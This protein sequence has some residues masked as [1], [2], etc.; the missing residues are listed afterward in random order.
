MI[1]W[2]DDRRNPAENGY[3][4][5]AWAKTYDEAIASLET[6]EVELCSL[7]HDLTMS[8]TLGLT[9]EEKTG[10]NVIC[11]MEE[12]NIWPEQGVL[13]HSQNAA[14]RHRMLQVVQK[15]YGKLFQSPFYL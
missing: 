4:G 9:N 7:D 12:H 15:H 13:V 3:I 8:Q 5:A 2:L 6:G 11:Y 14:G 10:Y 1:L